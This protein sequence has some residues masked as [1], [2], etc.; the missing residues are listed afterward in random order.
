[1]VGGADG[2]EFRMSYRDVW[3]KIKASEEC[4]R[5]LLVRKHIGVPTGRLGA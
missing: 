1:M 3:G 4:L 2:K 5:R